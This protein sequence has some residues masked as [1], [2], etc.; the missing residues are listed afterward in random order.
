MFQAKDA[1]TT[2]AVF[3]GVPGYFRAACREASAGGSRDGGYENAGWTFA[4]NL[5]SEVPFGVEDDEWDSFVDELR[6]AVRREDDG[7]ALQWLVAHYP[8]C[9][10]LVPPRRRER[11]L[12]G[13][14]RAYDEEL[15]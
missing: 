3:R 8:R 13:V 5:P 15:L 1:S 12:R 11:F 4:R 6:D 10:A 7:A 14:A 2:D 9:M